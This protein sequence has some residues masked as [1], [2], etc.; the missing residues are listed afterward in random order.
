LVVKIF[1]FYDVNV[2]SAIL[3]FPVE[4]TTRVCVAF[5]SVYIAYRKSG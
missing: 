5:C 3:L 2:V 4:N 1:V